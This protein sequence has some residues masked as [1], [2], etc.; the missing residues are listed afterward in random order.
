MAD[1]SLFNMLGHLHCRHLRDHAES[2]Q[3]FLTAASTC[4]PES[5]EPLTQVCQV[6]GVPVAQ[7]A[8]LFLLTW[9]GWVLFLIASTMGPGW[10]L[11]CPR[12]D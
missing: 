11:N 10:G 6:R 7:D 12:T 9:W 1:Q 4:H 3:A 5:T 2:S 8:G